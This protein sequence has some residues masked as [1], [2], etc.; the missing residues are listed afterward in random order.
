MLYSLYEAQ[1]AALQ[2]LRLAAEMSRG[3]FGHPFS[4]LAYAPM[5]RRLAAGSDLF[6]R[7]TQRYEKPAWR[8]DYTTV[9]GER[10]PVTMEVAPLL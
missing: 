3:W 7:L 9:G 10:V 8:V 1:H 6:L 5:S 2:P 4:P